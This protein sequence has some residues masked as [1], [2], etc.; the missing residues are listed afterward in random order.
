MGCQGLHQVDL[1]SEYHHFERKSSKESQEKMSKLPKDSIISM[2]IDYKINGVRPPALNLRK[3][4]D[5]YEK[6]VVFG[7]KLKKLF[8]DGKYTLR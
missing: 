4:E 7:K 8:S 6:Q 2:Y 1:K 5:E 3:I